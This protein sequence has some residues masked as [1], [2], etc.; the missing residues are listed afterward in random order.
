MHHTAVIVIFRKYC[1][2]ITSKS[3]IKYGGSVIQVKKCKGNEDKC[4]LKELMFFP[5]KFPGFHVWVLVQILDQYTHEE[6]VCYK[7][8]VSFLR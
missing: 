1:L 2:L 3:R 4:V 8:N 6:G 5:Q 7:G